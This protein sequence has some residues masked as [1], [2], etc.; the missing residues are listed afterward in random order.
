MDK[1]RAL[2][3]WFLTIATT[4]VV[5]AVALLHIMHRIGLI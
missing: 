3:L 5:I 2:L 1:I 4:A